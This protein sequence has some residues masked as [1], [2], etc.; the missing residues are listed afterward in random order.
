MLP[1]RWR[2][3]RSSGCPRRRLRPRA[4]RRAPSLRSRAVPGTSTRSSTGRRSAFV[5]DSSARDRRP[6][7]TRSTAIAASAAGCADGVP[8]SAPQESGQRSVGRTL[9]GRSERRQARRARFRLSRQSRSES[10][11]AP[12]EGPV[13]RVQEVAL[14]GFR[15]ACPSAAFAQMGKSRP[16]FSFRAIGAVRAGPLPL[17]H[18]DPG[19]RRKQNSARRR[20]SNAG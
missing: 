2:L 19:S 18:G 8:L 11:G 13:V 9:E 6:A 1:P 14:R 7:S 15:A 16:R 5:V 17:F 10:L 12:R 4:T 3:L 20:F